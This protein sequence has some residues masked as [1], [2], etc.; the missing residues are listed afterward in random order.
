M[1]MAS[2]VGPRLDR[3]GAADFP[4]TVFSF[5]NKLHSQT[6]LKAL[7]DGILPEGGLKKAEPVDG[8]VLFLQYDCSY[9]AFVKV[10]GQWTCL[11]RYVH[12][13]PFERF[14]HRHR[15]RHPV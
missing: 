3:A 2:Q 14:R 8:E 11:G 5:N 1:Q 13:T 10:S 7:A 9:Y 15:H 6:W 12:R 4:S